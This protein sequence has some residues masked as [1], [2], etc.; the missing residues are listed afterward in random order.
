M[1][2]ELIQIKCP[3]D[4]A[5]LS[6]KR[7]PG[8]ENKNV[9]CPVCGNKYPFSQYRI[10][11]P[12]ANA[13]PDTEYPRN[14][15]YGSQDESTQYVSGSNSEETQVGNVNPANNLILG[16]LKIQGTG[17]A[18]QLK[19]GKNVIG[20]KASNSTANFQIDTNGDKSMSREHLVVEV[21]RV[22]KLGYVHYVSLYKEKVNKTLVDNTPLVY[23]DC[24]VL[25]HGTLLKLPGVNLIFEVPDEE[26]TEF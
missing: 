26:N 18:F 4:G 11:T 21:K 12:S 6:V 14:R 2:D 19:P 1:E 24:L 10:V 25:Q 17:K 23:G 20:R 8:I 3:F 15:G 22:P 5:V 13:D 7:R 16:R 9:T